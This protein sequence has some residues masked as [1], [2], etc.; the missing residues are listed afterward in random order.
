MAIL[1]F[2]LTD[3]APSL[4][5]VPPLVQ[6][7]LLHFLTPILAWLSDHVYQLLVV[8][9]AT[10]PL[11]RLGQS[12]DPAPVIAAC[13]AYYHQAGPG[14]PPTYSIQTLV[15]AEIVRAWAHTCS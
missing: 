5:D 10:H 12:Y 4:P 13:A 7:L 1:A 15:H 6:F 2:P 11:V 8:R 3:D 14:K 9:C